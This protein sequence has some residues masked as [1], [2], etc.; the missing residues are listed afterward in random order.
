MKHKSKILAGVVALTVVGGAYTVV[1]AQSRPA[2]GTQAVGARTVWS[3]VYTTAQA[4][5]G[6]AYYTERCAVCHGSGLQGADVNPA[7]A[8]AQFTSRW[9]GQTV[10]ALS[11]RIRTTMPLDEPGSMTSTTATDVSAYLLMRNLYPAGTTELPRGAPPQNAIR[12]V[13][14]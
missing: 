6:R 8:G 3:G 4:N 12:F 9:R 14:R 2:A 5:R 10:G 1:E 11:N 13:D 7:L